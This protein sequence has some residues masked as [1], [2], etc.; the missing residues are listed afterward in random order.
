MRCHMPHHIYV[1]GINGSAGLCELLTYEN[2]L[3]GVMLSE[4]YTGLYS[5]L[6]PW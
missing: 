2:M 5:L 3:W 1:D 4:L 6:G